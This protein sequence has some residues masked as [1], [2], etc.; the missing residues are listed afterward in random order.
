MKHFFFFLSLLAFSSTVLAEKPNVLFI[1]IDD[2]NDWI[3]FM[4]GHPNS[5]T[6]HIDAL[7]ESGTAFTNAHCQSPL[8]NPSRTSL[9]L[10]LRPST[11]GVYGL[12]PWFR[13]LPEYENRVTLSQHFMNNGYTTFYTG[14]IYHG[15]GGR[16]IGKVG[17][18]GNGSKHKEWDVVGPG[19]S[20]KPFPPKKLVNTPQPHK[21]VDWGFF[22]H[23][24]EDKGDHICATWTVEQLDAMPKDEPFF[25]A[26]GFF[27]PHVPCYATQKWFDMHPESET[28]LPVIQR[29][30]RKDT[31]RFSWYLHWKLPEPRLK[32]LEDSDEWMNLTRSYLACT[33]FVDAQVKRVLDAVERNGFKENT[34]VVLWSDHG[35]HIGEK[36]ITGK[37]TLWD[38]G[39]RVPLVFAGPGVPGGQVCTKPAELLD[40]YPTLIDLCGLPKRDDLEGI[41]LLPQI[42]DPSTDRR[43]AITTHNHDN[44]GV[45]SEAWRYIVYADG[46]EELYDMKNDPNEWDNLIAPDKDR[47]KYEK[48]IAE[49]R[50]HLPEVN[51]KPAKGSRSRVLTLDE[52]GTLIWEGEEIKK[53]DPI[54]E[55]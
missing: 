53:D 29:D 6:P 36:E 34:I 30:D 9:M 24:D 42:K 25:M 12:A 32:F 18:K 11:T 38:D 37:N 2:Q 19:A 1:A 41:S 27:L 10:S 52:D 3:G 28:K 20:G 54:P 26:C 39:T 17:P 4:D 23:K 48:I 22:P 44:H 5:K 21:L 50:K 15:G 51:R 8:C 33:T 43:P 49:H 31:P 45:R 16:S 55:I 7:A 40:I 13:T 47:S 14:K 46:S 35:W